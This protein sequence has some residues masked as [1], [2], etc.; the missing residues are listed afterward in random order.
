MKTFSSFGQLRFDV[1]NVRPR[2]ASLS[3]LPSCLR[4]RSSSRQAANW[5]RKSGAARSPPRLFC[6]ISSFSGSHRCLQGLPAGTE[7][8]LSC[9]PPRLLPAS[10]AASSEPPPWPAGILEHGNVKV[11]GLHGSKS[12]L[13]SHRHRRRSRRPCEHRQPSSPEWRQWPFHRCWQ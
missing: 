2:H 9:P 4:F 11:T 3:R 7:C 6:A 13:A 10:V 12:V 8:R 5:A 1:S